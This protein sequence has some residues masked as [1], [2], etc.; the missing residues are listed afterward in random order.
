MEYLYYHQIFDR[1]VWLYDTFEGMTTPEEVDIDLKNQKASDIL[2]QVLCYSSM[3][4][5]KK[6]LSISKFPNENIKFVKG[7]VC[8]TLNNTDNLPNKISLLR[9]DTDWYKSTKKEMDILYPI[10]S[11]D[12]ILIVDDYGHW[13][14]AKIAI[15]EY[16]TLHNLSPIINNIDYTGIKIIK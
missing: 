11:K 5:V 8:E 9:L 3:D 4:E 14:G 13:R 10:L 7:D 15:D 6:N 16:F 2:Q 1:N 12:G